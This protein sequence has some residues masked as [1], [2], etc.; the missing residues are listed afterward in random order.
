M[1]VSCTNALSEWLVVQVIRDGRRYEQRFERGTPV[2]DLKV[3]GTAKGSG[4][5]ITFKPD[6]QIFTVT[7]F[8][9]ETIA[10]RLRELSYL[11]GGVRIT[12][13][14]EREAARSGTVAATRS[15]S[16]GGIVMRPA[17]Q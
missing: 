3:V 14:D 10:H 8:S 5:T 6:P 9:F 12:L 7:D 13:T 11:A 1:G 4:T 2:T 16:T 15:S 17:P